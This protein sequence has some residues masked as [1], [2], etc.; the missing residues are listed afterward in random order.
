MAQVLFRGVPDFT[1]VHLEVAK[2]KQEI[3]GI[4]TTPVRTT[5]AQQD[6]E[7]LGAAAKGTA[8][9]LQKMSTTFDG[10]GNAT[11]QVK[12]FSV[13]LGS[14][15]R[16][17]ATLNKETG[18]L[19]VTQKTLS[20]NFGQASKAV[21]E[22]TARYEAY[23]Q[24]QRQAM[25]APTAMQR[26]IEDLTG[27]ST[28]SKSAA[29]SASVFQKSWVTNSQQVSNALSSMG[30]QVGVFVGPANAGASAAKEY[31]RHIDGL[32]NA[33]VK[34]TGA[35][36]NAAGEFQTFTASVEN[37]DGTLSNFQVA[38]D[39]STGS[40]YKL[41]KG[42]SEATNVQKSLLTNFK[43]MVKYQA[44][45]MSA[46]AVLN[47]FGDA[48]EQMKKV[49]DELVVVRKV[50]GATTEE[51]ESLKDRAYETASAYG[52]MADE[53]LNSVSAFTRA[54]YKEHAADLA[55]LATK[56]K[57]V[58]D[59][60][61]ETAQQY[62]LSVDAAYQYNGNIQKL[63]AV[64]DGANEIDNKYATSIEKIAEGL[65]TVAPVAAQAHVGIDELTAAIGTIT[66]V[67]QRSGSEAARAFRAL[68][69]NILGDTKTEIDEGVTWTTG[70]IAGLKDVIKL[71]AKD[72]YDA[73]QATGS[74]INP[75]KAI[76]GLAQSMKEGVL[77]E[78]KLMEM[79]SDIGG[80]LRTSQLLA[81]IQNWDMYESMLADYGNA[82]GSADKEVENAL[83]SWTRKTNILSNKWAEF[84]S[85]LVDTE[86]IKSGLDVV[87]GLVEALDTDAGQLILTVAAI[88]LGV[89]GVTAAVKGLGK[90]W[91]ALSLKSLNPWLITL[92][93]ASAAVL[94]LLKVT[95]DQRKS[96]EELDAALEESNGK[97]EENRKRLQEIS[98][99]PW[100]ERT[101]EIRA[102]QDALEKENEALQ[103]QIDKYAE[104]KQ[105]KAEEILSGSSVGTTVGTVSYQ[106]EGE[107]SSGRTRRRKR[108]SEVDAERMA[109]FYTTLTEK[110][111]QYQGIL[112]TAHELSDEQQEDYDKTVAQ[113]KRYVTAMEAV[114]G[115]V[116]ACTQEQQTMYAAF[117]ETQTA[118]YE[119]QNYIQIYVDSLVKQAEATKEADENL[120]DLAAEMVAVNNQNLTFSQQIAAL[121]N[122]ATQ[123]GITTQA[124]SGVMGNSE[125]ASRRNL[126]AWMQTVNPAT[127]KNYTQQEAQEAL[128]N[129][130]WARL[131]AQG[132][133]DSGSS[134]S[135][136]GSS[137]GSAKSQTDKQLEAR[138]ENVSL[139]KSELTLMEKQGKSVGEQVAKI[140]AIQ[141]AL[142]QQAEYMRSIGASQS[143]I[144][145]LSA[146]WYDWQEKIAA[147]QKS[148]LSELDSA[149]QK[150]LDDAK[151]DRDAELDAIQAQIDALKEKNEAEDTA[152][153]IEEKRAAITE[154]QNDL[155]EKQKALLEA[156]N[157]RTVRTYNAK[158]NQWEWIADAKNVKSAEDALKSA[159]DALEKAKDDLADYNKKLQRDAEIAALEAKKDQINAHYD[160]L[161]NAW[162]RIMDALGD[163]VR[164][165][166]DI[167]KDIAENATPEL[168]AQI[169]KNKDLFAALG[170]DLSAFTDVVKTQI[171]KIYA[172][173]S[174]GQQYG[175]G[176][177][178]GL[179]F[180][181]NAPAGSTMT[182]S[183]GSQW[184]KNPDGT[185][186]IT[187]NGQTYTT[188][189]QPNHIV[190]V[191]PDGKAPPG[192]GVGDWVVTAAGTYQITAVNPDG[193]YQS[194]LIDR[195]KTTSTY[196]GPYYDKGGWLNGMGGIKATSRPETVLPP[197]LTEKL[198]SPAADATFRKRMG[199]LGFLY[200]AT[201]KTPVT[202]GGAVTNSNVTNNNGAHYHYRDIVLTEEQARGMSL[203][204]LTK[205]SG[206]LGNFNNL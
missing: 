107:F 68:V 3:A 54:G 49:D 175:I 55:E 31:I 145:A 159:Q 15:Q 185:T 63:S 30:Q 190:R 28:A 14:T 20:H 136:G 16:V 10:S 69:L 12:E 166:N 99:I 155:L 128:M 180:V 90:A 23:I 198:L 89:I 114:S 191:Q 202:A 124:I 46:I 162:S 116:S 206:N 140:K 51:L 144:N 126:A 37:S 61:A 179:D 104:L 200:G 153:E 45:W 86:T 142:H 70:E 121:Q 2:I 178:R 27:V 184:T 48:F 176:S 73:A 134:E 100:S 78:Q 118:Y 131:K 193:S 39:K 47:A 133:G 18:E 111:K 57:I 154:R 132:T 113:A 83:D 156:R 164:E 42:T 152:L 186:T 170:I 9:E 81:L 67:T 8:A 173:S 21:S 74:V 97:L 105:K 53:Y 96:I 120:Y 168:R 7:R 147:L 201:D 11:R 106:V 65:G 196:P 150:K 75:M 169:L 17:V 5:S 64:L 135:G 122:L 94:A 77:T 24:A 35:V 6:I 82:V 62:L 125:V 98:E 91:K 148:L 163:P 171:E 161:E 123:A 130:Y 66:A 194:V 72:A 1:Q 40:V 50:T 32:G 204:Q 34:A 165:I 192:C 88:E 26:Q 197:E 95:E 56:T 137:S 174:G 93:A 182:G 79:V 115:G 127:G 103:D 146:E 119:A 141:N 189:G 102:E 43:E 181:N 160:A 188:T 59:T 139:L 80:K 101:S 108:G 76:G 38:I 157:E 84:I 112:N 87:I 4:S 158:T 117:Q 143:E 58:G 71:Y 25:S 187:K 85:H 151:T 149:V 183:D 41:S 203:Y 44:I 109:N 110:L 129:A 167:L 199:E 138:K 19:A 13:G 172:I 195:S 29:E 36:R 22:A 177:D 60:T 33:S 52:E 92:A 205:L